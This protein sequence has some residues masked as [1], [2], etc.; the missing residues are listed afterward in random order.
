MGTPTL[1]KG[2]LGSSLPGVSHPAQRSP[3]ERSWAA[4]FVISE[5]RRY[6]GAWGECRMGR[7]T[8]PVMVAGRSAVPARQWASDCPW[9]HERFLPTYVQPRRYPGKG[10][11]R[12]K[13]R[14]VGVLLPW[15]GSSTG[16]EALTPWWWNEH[17]GS[18]LGASYTG[19]VSLQKFID[20]YTHDTSTLCMLLFIGKVF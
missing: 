19:V 8:V 15:G 6:P 16:G 3:E 20:L 4:L 10:N 1:R 12:Q 2:L 11:H 13:Q 9:P 7:K 17:P 5:A 14:G 18:Q